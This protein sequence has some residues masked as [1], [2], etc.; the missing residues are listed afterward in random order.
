[1]YC[2]HLALSAAADDLRVVP[3]GF[4]RRLWLSIR[5]IG[6]CLDPSRILIE[7]GT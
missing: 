2:C 5:Q 3:D 7:V 4:S 1:M 6:F